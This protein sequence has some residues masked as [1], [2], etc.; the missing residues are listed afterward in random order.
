M[1]ECHKTLHVFFNR[2]YKI[3]YL[4]VPQKSIPL[5]IFFIDFLLF[6]HL[7]LR[8]Y[9]RTHIRFPRCPHFHIAAANG[10]CAAHQPVA[11]TAERKPALIFF[12]PCTVV[13]LLRA[14]IQISLQIPPHDGHPCLRL[15]P[16]HYRADSG[17]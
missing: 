3:W 10:T 11:L 7:P 14:Y 8:L 4:F 6:I 13:T 12:L 2:L 16:S 1:S 5:F 15:Y 17:L 9:C